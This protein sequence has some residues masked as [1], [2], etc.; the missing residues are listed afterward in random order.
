MSPGIINNIINII[1]LIVSHSYDPSLMPALHWRIYVVRILQKLRTFKSNAIPDPVEKPVWGHLACNI[2]III[3]RP[4][5]KL[6]RN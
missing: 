6:T 4:V 2:I 1:D 5:G 3:L